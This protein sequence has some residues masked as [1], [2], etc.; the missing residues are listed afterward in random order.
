MAAVRAVPLGLDET[1]RDRILA[2]LPV[3][4]P[5]DLE[6]LL[7]GTPAS[8]L[9]M[10]IAFS[11]F[12]AADRPTPTER[13]LTLRQIAEMVRSTT[14]TATIAA[15][16][17]HPLLKLALFNGKRNADNMRLVTGVEIDHDDG[18]I[19]PDEAL[20]A[21]QDAGVA[22]LIYTTRKDV[23]EQRRWRAL[24]P[25]SRPLIPSQRRQM[26]E[27][28]LRLL[29]V[30]NDDAGVSTA[31]GTAF[32][33]AGV[34]GKPRFVETCPGR[35]LDLVCPPGDPELDDLLGTAPGDDTLDELDDLAAEAEAHA[36]LRDFED[37]VETGKLASALAGIPLETME[38][39]SIRPTVI[40]VGFALHHASGGSEAGLALWQEF[41]NR[42]QWYAEQLA[43]GRS[44]AALARRQSRVWRRMRQERRKVISLG[45]V[46]H[47][48]EQHGWSRGGTALAELDDLGLEPP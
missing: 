3:S 25:F 19:G 10:P 20:E 32:Y 38:R 36:R 16:T 11:T 7:G 18:D 30:D 28:A 43:T 40:E 35:F 21:L 39:G 2:Q 31:E 17:E 29:G 26:A 46:Y 14:I 9:D 1:E 48:A 4:I 22:A 45:S 8:A 37:A 33:Y 13:T 12:K 41:A 42:S 44:P 34:E 47:L 15:T 24:L 23:P 6:D 27:A 5:D